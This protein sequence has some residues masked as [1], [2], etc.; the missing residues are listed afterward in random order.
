[1]KNLFKPLGFSFLTPFMVGST[2]LMGLYVSNIVLLL[3]G[4]AVV[5]GTNAK[6]QFKYGW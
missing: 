5:A 4:I 1:M 6:M 2:V 3:G